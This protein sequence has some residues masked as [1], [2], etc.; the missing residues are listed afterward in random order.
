MTS[1]D[2]IEMIF[3]I[4]RSNAKEEIRNL[5][6]DLCVLQ[7]YENGFIPES[8]LKRGTVFKCTD[9]ELLREGIEVLNNYARQA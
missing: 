2:Q 7:E 4:D 5:R 1:I 3:G 8:E 9:Q 6:N